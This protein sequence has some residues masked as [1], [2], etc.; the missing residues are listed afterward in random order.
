[1]T[2]FVYIESVKT[3]A[4]H[5]EP[6]EADCPTAAAVEALERLR[7]HTSATTA[8]VFDGDICLTSVRREDVGSMTPDGSRAVRYR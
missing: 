1:M 7:T 4:L 5:M 8:H 6:L 2:Y 3:A